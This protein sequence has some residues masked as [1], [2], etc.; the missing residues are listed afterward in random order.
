MTTLRVGEV[1]LK[2]NKHRRNQAS[3]FLCSHSF[4]QFSSDSKGISNIGIVW[5]FPE[6]SLIFRYLIILESLM[7]DLS[8]IIFPIACC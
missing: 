4:C 1:D 2:K 7:L 5:I 3:V 6:E 8:G